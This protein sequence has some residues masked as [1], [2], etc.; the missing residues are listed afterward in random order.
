MYG[1]FP[2]LL[3]LPA[4]SAFVQ[5]CFYIMDFVGRGEAY[6]PFFASYLRESAGYGIAGCRDRQQSFILTRQENFKLFFRIREAAGV[7]SAC[8][9]GG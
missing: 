6:R 7:K 5:E 1:V 3:M 4:G 8:R 2:I 9:C